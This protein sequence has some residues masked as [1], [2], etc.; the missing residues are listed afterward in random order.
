MTDTLWSDVSEF[1]VAVS[2]SYPY[3]FL[4]FR[5]NDGNYLDHRFA[6]NMAWCHGARASG[7]LWGFMVYY[8]YRPGVNGAAVLKARV[9]TP[10]SR[11]VA[12]IDV[13][14]AGGSIGGNQSAQI[15]AEFE[16]LAAWL[17]DPRRVVGYGNVSDLNA[18]WP[19]KPS[20]ARLIVAAYGSNPSYPG[21]YAH[22]FADN[23]S[24]PPFGP[25]DI[26]SADGMGVAQ[27]EAMYG[28]SAPPPV[29]WTE[30]TTTMNLPTISQAAP[31]PSPFYVQKMQADLNVHTIG[32]GATVLTVDGSFGPATTTRLKQFQGS[33]GLAQDGVC[34]GKTW[35]ALE[36][37]PV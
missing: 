16:E 12:M 15:N 30:V 5:S 26:N 27:L 17:G 11:L 32:G 36:S 24:T 18:L 7:R 31:G 10:D 1:Q 37:D 22:Q 33:R 25:S 34:G 8:F 6:E 4:A 19:S 21:K 28:F 20:G 23:F 14:S 29:Q 13:E 2:N 9:G 35:A 3:G